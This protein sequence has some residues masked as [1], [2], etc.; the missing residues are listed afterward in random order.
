MSNRV[1][2]INTHGWKGYFYYL[3]FPLDLFRPDTDEQLAYTETKLGELLPVFGWLVPLLVLLTTTTTSMGF[4]ALIFFFAL[5]AALLA[6]L[7]KF[8]L[9]LAWNQVTELWLN[10]WAGMVATMIAITVVTF[11]F[12]VLTN[13]DVEFDDD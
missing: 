2:L 8:H 5:E 10:L 12:G 6:L 9:K 7:T 3:L 4:F 13:P 1:A 11:F